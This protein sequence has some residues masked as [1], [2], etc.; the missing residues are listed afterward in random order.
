MTSLQFKYDA[1][2]SIKVPMGGTQAR[3]VFA[4]SINNALIGLAKQHK[5]AFANV[6]EEM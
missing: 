6:H 3:T 4:L 2:F 5:K 1:I